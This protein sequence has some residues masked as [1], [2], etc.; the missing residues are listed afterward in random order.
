MVSKVSAA[1][2]VSVVGNALGGGGGEGNEGG[3]SG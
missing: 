3:T 2:N 1:N